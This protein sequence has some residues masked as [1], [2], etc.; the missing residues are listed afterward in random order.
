MAGPLVLGLL[1]EAT[2]HGM[3]WLC[4]GTLALDAMAEILPDR[5]ELLRNRDWS[6]G[7]MVRR[8]WREALGDIFYRFLRTIL[9]PFLGL[10]VMDGCGVIFS[11]GVA[12]SRNSCAMVA[13]NRT[14]S[15][16]AKDWPMQS[17]GPPPKGK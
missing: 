4:S 16:L 10:K 15:I 11:P 6:R 5:G 8:A 1:V 2:S 17:L 9:K 12:R 13:S 14:A 7:L 3:M